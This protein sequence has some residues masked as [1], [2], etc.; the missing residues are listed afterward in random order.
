MWL[1]MYAVTVGLLLGHTFGVASTPYQQAFREA[2]G[3]YARAM[4]S[5]QQLWPIS[6]VLVVS[7]KLPSQRMRSVSSPKP[8]VKPLRSARSG[9]KPSL[10]LAGGKPYHYQ[11]ES[12]N[13]TGGIVGV[14]SHYG[15]SFG[16]SSPAS[17]QEG[18]KWKTTTQHSAATVTGNTK[19][20]PITFKTATQ[21]LT[22]GKSVSRPTVYLYGTA[23]HYGS[24][25][26]GTLCAVPRMW[27]GRKVRITAPNGR[28]IV[29]T[30]NDFGPAIPG[31]CVDLDT[32]SFAALGYSPS[33]GLIPGIRVE[34]LGK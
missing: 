8:A 16:G 11:P 6:N 12:A 7:Y 33:Q 28:S 30:V 10:R 21:P 4:V 27:R 32:S 17:R 34:A 23:S 13:L 14:A 18:S 1:T 2:M 22:N 20:S 9:R 25:Y 19:K 31:R 29:R 15:T 26:K 24:K 3:P 5:V